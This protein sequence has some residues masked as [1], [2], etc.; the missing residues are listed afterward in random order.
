MIHLTELLNS[1]GRWLVANLWQMSIEL[2]ILAAVVAAAIYL[3][4]I[5]S[6]AWRHLFWS[7]VLAKPLV[8]LLIAS[9]VSLYWSTADAV[10]GR[11]TNLR[12]RPPRL[13]GPEG[14]ETAAK[15]LGRDAR[16][17]DATAIAGLLGELGYS[18]SLDFVS[19]KIQQFSQGTADRILVATLNSHVVGVLSLH[20]LPSLHEHANACRFTAFVVA[21]SH[22][23]KGI[24]R[25][26]MESAEAVA[27][28]SGCAKIE[29]TSGERRQEAHGLCR[30]MGCE[31]VSRR[32]L[33]SI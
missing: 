11:W 33:K 27:G 13:S 21:E 24:G 30:R 19:R 31:E 3:L 4:R 28:A 5:K 22:T 32:F 8:T 20:V 14:A 16:E 7:L 12:Q 6:P 1:L 15:L 23:G 10:G 29:V 18:N 25:K 26:L 17:I 9:P 2:A